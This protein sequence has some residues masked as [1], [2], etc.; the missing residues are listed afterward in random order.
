L[1]PFQHVPA[2][3]VSGVGV[4]QVHEKFII[5]HVTRQLFTPNMRDMSICCTVLAD[6]SNFPIS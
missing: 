4:Y 5:Q 3:T 2:L 1:H 6:G